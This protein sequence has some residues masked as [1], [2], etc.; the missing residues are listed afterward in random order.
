MLNKKIL[1]FF[2]IFFLVLT[3][4]S[5]SSYTPPTYN[6]VNFTLCDG[7]TAPTYNSINFTLGESDSCVVDTC[8]YS[9]GNWNI[10]LNDFCIIDSDTDLG[11]N[12][13]TFYGEGNVTFNAIITTCNV[14]GLPANQKGYLGS[15][16]RV[17]YGVC[18]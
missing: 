15:S 5:T 17:N 9:S 2:G 16:A 11:T 1:A 4:T 10:S 6:S 7:Y 12:N 18:Q 8:T 3:I 13:I 14:G